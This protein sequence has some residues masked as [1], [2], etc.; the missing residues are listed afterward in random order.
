MLARRRR[1]L[2]HALLFFVSEF[3]HAR[4]QSHG[5]HDVAA[6]YSSVHLERVNQGYFACAD[7][8]VQGFFLGPRRRRT[9][10]FH[11]LFFAQRCPAVPLRQGRGV[12]WY[13][14]P[15][16]AFDLVKGLVAGAA[17]MAL[18]VVAPMTVRAVKRLRARW[19]AR[20]AARKASRG[21]KQ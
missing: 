1:Q 13:F 16:L 21:A 9:G 15:E 12:M 10:L 17:S 20:R 4:F 5:Y 11:F 6:L 3:R 19:S 14:G 2:R 7:N 18:Q 8:C